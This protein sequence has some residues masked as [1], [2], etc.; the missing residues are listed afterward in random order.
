MVKLI[1]YCLKF[2]KN[3][4]KFRLDTSACKI[5]QIWV[6]RAAQKW[7]V[8]PFHVR[9]GTQDEWRGN[10]RILFK[11]RTDNQFAAICCRTPWERRAMSANV[12]IDA[13]LLLAA[14]VSPRAH[15][16]S[17]RDFGASFRLRGGG[18]RRWR[19]PQKLSAVVLQP[20]ADSIKMKYICISWILSH[21]GIWFP[22]GPWPICAGTQKK[23]SNMRHRPTSLCWLVKSWIAI[24]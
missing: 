17:A 16:S 2:P 13:L 5:Q 14:G 22:S 4:V 7:I 21:L 19:H 15:L 18:D 9:L 23:S 24:F 10:W 3:Y 11:C 6:S 12:L 8:H 20:R 1:F